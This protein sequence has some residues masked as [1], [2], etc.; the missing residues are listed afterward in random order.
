LA[1]QEKV[2]ET[3]APLPLAVDTMISSKF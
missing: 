3:L 2:W 1:R